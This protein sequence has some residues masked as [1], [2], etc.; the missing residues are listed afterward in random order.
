MTSK[1][2]DP[3]IIKEY[4]SQLAKKR[5]KKNPMSKEKYQEMQ[6]KSVIA[7]YKKLSTVE[8]KRVVA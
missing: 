3:E 4:F 2:I 8:D 6:K 1:N 7:R 5:H